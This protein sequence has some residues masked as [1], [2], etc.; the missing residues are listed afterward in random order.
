MVRKVEQAKLQGKAGR[1]PV[2]RNGG[3]DCLL[4]VLGHPT[5]AGPFEC[6]TVVV[7]RRLGSGGRVHVFVHPYAGSSLWYPWCMLHGED[8]DWVD[9]AA[10]SQMPGEWQVHIDGKYKLHH[11]KFLLLTIGTHYLRYDHHHSTLSNSFAPLVYLFCKEG[12]SDGAVQILIDALI[13]TGRK[14]YNVRLT[15]GAGASDHAP[16][17]RKAMETTWPGIEYGQC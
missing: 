4:S 7:A 17:L 9:G 11:S 12:E 3:P 14:Y 2:V 15:P 8:S 16:A 10:S 6:C 5:Y 13:A 1:A